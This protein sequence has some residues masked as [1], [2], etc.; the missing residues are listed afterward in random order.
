MSWHEPYIAL[1]VA[2]I[3]GI[4]GWFYFSGRSKAAGKPTLLTVKP[5]V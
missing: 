2:A 3:W 4:Y 5:A 1:A